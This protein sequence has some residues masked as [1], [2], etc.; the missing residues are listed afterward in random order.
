MPS[1]GNT[2]ANKKANADDYGRMKWLLPD[3]VDPNVA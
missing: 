3:E 1:T 2:L